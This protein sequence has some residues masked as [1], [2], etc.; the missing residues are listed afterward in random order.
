VSTPFFSN[1]AAIS[2]PNGTTIKPGGRVAAYVRS[3][4]AQD[5]DDQFAATGGLVTSINAGLARCR[6]GQNDIVYV[7]PGHVE[8]H[9]V[10]GSIW[11]ALVAGAQI[12]GAGVPGATNNP[13]VNISHAGATMALNLANVTV[14]GLNIASATATVTGAIVVTGAGV[15]LANNFINF[16]GAF[17]ANP[18]IA[19]TDAGTFSLVNNVIIANCTDPIVELTGTATL[20]FLI[21]RNFIRQAQATSGGGGVSVA[22]AVLTGM[23]SDNRFKTAETVTG[24]AGAFVIGTAAIGLVGNFENYCCDETAAAGLLSAGV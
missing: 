22:D 3:T 2:G 20:N 10:T 13:T 11:P 12:V 19:V 21:A 8:T 7:L 4:G 18:A 6:S 1:Y 15:T 23:I 14:A 9:S 5:G 17:G 16:T 24:A